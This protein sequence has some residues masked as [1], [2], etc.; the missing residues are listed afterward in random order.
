M[1]HE[2]GSA[3]SHSPP[4]IEV[5]YHRGSKLVSLTFITIDMS[6][7]PCHA[8]LSMHIKCDSAY[9]QTER[10]KLR[11]SNRLRSTRRLASCPGACLVSYNL[12]H[13]FQA[14]DRGVCVSHN[15]LPLR[16]ESESRSLQ[17][18]VKVLHMGKLLK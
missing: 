18:W 8:K 14:V 3:M 11:F 10:C 1:S 16:F 12:E 15:R 6:S 7:G 17:N 2:L 9:N 5:A 4:T 13:V